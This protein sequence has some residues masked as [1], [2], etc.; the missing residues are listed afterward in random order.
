MNSVFGKVN[1]YV[2]SLGLLFL[3]IIIITFDPIVATSRLT[4]L[5][6]WIDVVKINYVSLI[7]LG[8]MVYCG[9]AYLLFLH[10]LKGAT[11]LPFE[12]KKIESVEY[13]HLTF[14][15]TYVVPLI[16]FEFGSGRQL[17]VLGLLL[18]AMGVIYV[19]TDLFYANPSL[20]LLGFRIYRVD[21]H[22][23]TGDRQGIVV[24][25]RSKLAEGQKATY[26]KLDDKIYF[27]KGFKE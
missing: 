25:C 20:A 6:G 15:A 9:F 14:L 11:D 5:D 1:L 13:E 2:L 24:I 17:L 7:A 8:G 18:I 21:G 3:F 27:A 16:S 12:I 10:Q 4:S 23:K 19:K 26:I 22:F